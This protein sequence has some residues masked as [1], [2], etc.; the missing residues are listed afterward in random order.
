M[1]DENGQEWSQASVVSAQMN[2][3]ISDGSQENLRDGALA[4][5]K[6]IKYDKDGAAIISVQALEK[7][8]RDVFLSEPTPSDPV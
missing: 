3:L 1:S 6:E 7:F 4:K 5:N 2:S 8:N